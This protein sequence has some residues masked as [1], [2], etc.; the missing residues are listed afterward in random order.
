ME[1]VIYR[2]ELVEAKNDAKQIIN[3]CNTLR[4]LGVP[5]IKEHYM[6]ENNK[7]VVNSSTNMYAKLHKK[8]TALLHTNEYHKVCQLFSRKITNKAYW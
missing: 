5:I 3:L 4:Y 8:H 7:S 1:I 6:F 2:S